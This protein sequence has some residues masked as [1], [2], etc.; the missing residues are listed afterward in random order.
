MLCKSGGLDR[1]QIGAIRL[2]DATSRVELRADAADAFFQRIGPEGRLEKS[3]TAWREGEMPASWSNKAD[4]P[5]S[6][7]GKPSKGKPAFKSRPKAESAKPKRKPR[8]VPPSQLKDDGKDRPK[9]GKP[10]SG[11]KPKRFSPT[12]DMPPRR[13]KP[14]QSKR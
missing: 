3:I 14:K 6:G 7:G 11:A 2:E 4:S 5:K 9:R 8:P 1:T 13:K 10:A 12:A